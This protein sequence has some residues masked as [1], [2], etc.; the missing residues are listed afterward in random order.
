MKCVVISEKNRLFQDAQ[1]GVESAGKIKVT[2]C[3]NNGELLG[4]YPEQFGFGPIRQDF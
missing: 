2:Q 3:D 4:I 1:F